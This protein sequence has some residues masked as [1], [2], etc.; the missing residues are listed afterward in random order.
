MF[1]Y[2][3]KLIALV[4]NYGLAYLMEENE[5][6]EEYVVR[7]LVDEGLIDFDDYF[8]VD[9]EMQHWKELEE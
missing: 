9:A 1:D 3:S 6:S 7:F 4:Q 5:I 8:N 2:D